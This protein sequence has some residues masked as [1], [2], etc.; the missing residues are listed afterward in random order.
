[1]ATALKIYVCSEYRGR[2]E[3]LKVMY[4]A[5]VYVTLKG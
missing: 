2:F 4:V 3:V 1:M 5:Y